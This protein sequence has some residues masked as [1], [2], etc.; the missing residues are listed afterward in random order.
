M[1]RI[2]VGKK[3]AQAAEALPEVLVSLRRFQDFLQLP[4]AAQTTADPTAA[5]VE[6]AAPGN[7]TKRAIHL[8]NA[9][10]TWAGS[11]ET[12]AAEN[13]NAADIKTLALNDLDF[14][15]FAGEHVALVGPVGS[16][17]SS[18]LQA[19]AGEMRHTGGRVFTWPEAIAYAPQT[20]WIFAGTLKQNILFGAPMDEVRY[21]A[22][23][24]ACALDKDV[25][26]LPDGEDTEIGEKVGG[27]GLAVGTNKKPIIAAPLTS[28]YAVV[29]GRQPLGGTKGARV[30]CAGS[31]FR[32]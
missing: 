6:P 23:L 26:Q 19:L 5:N 17:K 22:T 12:D 3:F 1:L 11:S 21:R 28:L 14:E 2:G 27:D 32:W 7:L 13:K 9:S 8:E 30:P 24:A 4:D 18:L 15:V 25:E 31:L 16:G 10:F 20:P 29:T